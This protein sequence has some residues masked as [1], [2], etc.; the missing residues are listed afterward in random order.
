MLKPSKLMIGVAAAAVLAAGAARAQESGLKQVDRLVKVSG[1]AVQSIAEAKMQLDKTMTRYNGIM[2]EN[3]KDR[4]GSYKNLIKDRDETVKKVAAVSERVGIMEAEAETLFAAWQKEAD[5][6]G[7]AALREKSLARLTDTKTRFNGILA[8]GRSARD[9]Y[10]PFMKAL[11]DQI[12]FLG[13][14]LNAGAVA[15]LKPNAA[16]LNT[17]ATKL[18]S[19]IDETMKVAREY[20]NS[21]RP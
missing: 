5:A 16:K 2:D 12:T 13:H 7:D 15:S 3:A 8:A 10:D 20:M 1:D 11:G 17:D 19:K 6:I 4:T 9:T 14:D 18:G 21:L